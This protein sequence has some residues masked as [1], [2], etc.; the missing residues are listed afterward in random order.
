VKRLLLV[1]LAACTNEV[2]PQWQLDHERVIA[3]R[4]TP[5][6][7]ASGETS[8]I[9]ALLGHKDA[10][11]DA[12]K[13]DDAAIESPSGLDG[14]LAHGAAGWTVTAPSDA[15]LA[16][17]R[18]QLGLDA[19]APIPLQIELTFE[20]TGLHV[21][22]IVWLGEHTDNPT[23][24]P[25]TIDGSG[26]PAAGTQLSVAAGVDIPLAVEFD[27]SY[28]INWLTSCGTMHDFDLPRAYLRV[29]AADPHSGALGVVVRDDMG[30][31]DW[32]VWPIT[33]E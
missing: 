23:I 27:D 25:V 13:P 6:R 2:D 4:A 30:G 8:V 31:V 9:D 24:D 19:D 26:A 20:A 28:V 16:A 33:A 10:P 18:A 5:P 12:G 21:L 7:I 29:E 14:A 11:P 15:Q 3:V 1:A 22:K 32:R 17:V